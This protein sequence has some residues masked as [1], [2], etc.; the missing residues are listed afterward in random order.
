MKKII[1]IFASFA[2]FAV[3][4]CREETSKSE[5]VIIEKQAEGQKEDSDG[6]SLSV[7][8]NG[9]EFSTKDGDKKTDINIGN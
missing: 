3:V 9:V 2:I 8:K 5:T 1:L 7:D 6:T 4:S